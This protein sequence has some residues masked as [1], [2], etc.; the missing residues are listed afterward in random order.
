MRTLQLKVEADRD[1]MQVVNDLAIMNGISGYILGVVGDLSRVVFQCP[2]RTSLTEIQGKLEI[3]T[4]NGTFNPQKTHLHVSV[5]DE[6]CKV[7][8]GH[9]SKGTLVLNGAQILLGVLASSDSKYIETKDIASSLRNPIA[10]VRIAILPDCA[11]SKR[12]LRILHSLDINYDLI[13]V[14]TEQ[15]YL[16]IKNKTNLSRFPQLFIDERIVG[17]YE[18]LVQMQASGKLDELRR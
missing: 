1:L 3:I 8:G 4:L 12:A 5:S 10:R 17:G 11:W 15:K 14:D 13:I 16:A 2:N 7:W 18:E 6:N 9:L